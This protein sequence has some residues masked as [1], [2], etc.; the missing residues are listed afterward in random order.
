MELEYFVEVDYETDFFWRKGHEE[1]AFSEK[2]RHEITS[3]EQKQWKSHYTF[4][5][6][7]FDKN[8]FFRQDELINIMEDIENKIDKNN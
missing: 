5:L 2:S 8:A 4:D 1:F 3:K 6:D 7:S